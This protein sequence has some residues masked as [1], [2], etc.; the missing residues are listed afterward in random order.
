M[1]H[2]PTGVFSGA[3]GQSIWTL[4]AGGPKPPCLAKYCHWWSRDR[5]LWK[6][7]P[8]PL[9]P[10][11]MRMWLDVP[12]H[13]LQQK[14]KPGTCWSL[15]PSV[16]QLSLGPGG[17]SSK[18]STTDLPKGNPFQNHRWLPCSLGHPSWSVMEVPP[19]SS[20]KSEMDNGL[21]LRSNQITAFG[22]W[23]KPTTA[24]EWVNELMTSYGQISLPMTA[25]G[26]KNYNA[27][28]W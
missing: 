3:W 18:E 16:E 11:L 7:P 12:P 10:L 4:Q 15:L 21:C 26:Q 13:C 20:W 27:I 1:S 24:V 19:W 14:E 2:S 25:S 28:G 8:T 22:W 9:P 17:N 6:P 5:I 23:G